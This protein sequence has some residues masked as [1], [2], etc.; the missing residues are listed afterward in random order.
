MRWRELVALPGGA[1]AIT[2]WPSDT[3]AAGTGRRQEGTMPEPDRPGISAALWRLPGQLLL[4][5]INATSILVI[6]AAILA[7]VAIARIN[8]FAESVVATMTE[9]VLSKVDL[10]SKDVLANLRNLT[11]EVRALGNSLRE[12]KAGENPSLQFEMAQLKEAL[13]VLNVSVDRLGSAKSILTDEAIGKL[14]RSVT[15]MLMKLRD[16]S[17]NVGQIPPHH[18]PGSLSQWPLPQR[19]PSALHVGGAADTRLFSASR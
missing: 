17:S 4:A 15:D 16:C 11:A 8:H 3:R 14:G 9:A 12:I 6:V 18:T 5:L 19:G 1:I 7:L 2:K 10:P 13:T